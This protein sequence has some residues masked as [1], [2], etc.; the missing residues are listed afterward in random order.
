MTFR[1]NI[2]GHIR[3]SCAVC[4][5]STE[6]KENRM[7]NENEMKNAACEAPGLAEPCG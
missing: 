2:L 4:N 6:R 1:K 5:I 7:M 3:R